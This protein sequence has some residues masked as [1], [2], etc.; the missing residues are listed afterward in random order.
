MGHGWS[1]FSDGFLAVFAP[2][3]MVAQR[4]SDL[5]KAVSKLRSLANDYRN[6]LQSYVGITKALTER[7]LKLIYILGHKAT[8][9]SILPKLPSMATLDDSKP[10]VIAED[11]VKMISPAISLAVMM[12]PEG[13]IAGLLVPILASGIVGAIQVG[14]LDDDIF[15]VNDNYNK[16]AAVTTPNSIRIATYTTDTNNINHQL[17][18]FRDKFFSDLKVSSWEEVANMADSTTRLQRDI[19]NLGD[20]KTQAQAQAKANDLSNETE[21][22]H[23][24]RLFQAKQELLQKIDAMKG[25]SVSPRSLHIA[26]RSAVPLKPVTTSRSVEMQSTPL[27]NAPTSDTPGPRFYY[28]LSQ[29]EHILETLKLTTY[30]LVRQDVLLLRHQ[31]TLLFITHL[32]TAL[33]TDLPDVKDY[34]KDLRKIVRESLRDADGIHASGIVNLQLF[35]DKGSWLQYGYDMGPLESSKKMSFDIVVPKFLD[36]ISPYGADAGH[37]NG[38]I[39]LR[40][41]AKEVELRAAKTRLEGVRATFEELKAKSSRLFEDHQEAWRS[42]E[43]TADD[44]SG[45]ISEVMEVQSTLSLG[46]IEDIV[47]KNIGDEDSRSEL[48]ELSKLRISLE[49]ALAQIENIEAQKK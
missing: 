32:A 46:A 36:S 18:T 6:R 9:S 19:D 33:A 27:A 41:D 14:E 15:K 23:F 42:L 11:V 37:A 1:K 47:A 2:D 16:L 45:M 22:S 7:E 10:F 24:L 31:I 21:K 17:D 26:P 48:V 13:Q 44:V 8:V 43:T 4:K 25:V 20:V 34:Y 28:S 49:K 35:N 40:L 29:Q 38:D 39:H 5:N 3:A 12:L 30:V